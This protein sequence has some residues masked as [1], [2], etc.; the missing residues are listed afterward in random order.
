MPGCARNA[1]VLSGIVIFWLIT[2]ASSAVAGP[3]SPDVEAPGIFVPDQGCF[4]VGVEYQYEHLSVLGVAFHD[5]AYNA[6]F[7]MHLFDWLTGAKGR[8][9]VGVEASTTEGFGGRVNGPPV[10]DAKSFFVGAGPHIALQSR[11][12][13]EPWI[14]GLVGWERLRFTQTA[15]LGVNS[16]VGFFIGGGVDYR[17]TSRIAWRVE[18]NYFGTNYQSSIQSNFTTGTGIVINF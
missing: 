14:H 3:C 8:L 12:R 10:L 16:T 17:L 15:T 11:S 7:Q 6:N 1:V 2:A 18:G 13:F 4:R 5:H 9:A